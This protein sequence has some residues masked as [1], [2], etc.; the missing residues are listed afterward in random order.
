[1][2]RQNSEGERRVQGTEPK[3]PRIRRNQWEVSVADRKARL[4]AV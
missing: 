2:V 4:E 3:G 1:M